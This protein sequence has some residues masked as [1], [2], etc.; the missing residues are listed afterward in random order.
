MATDSH[1]KT[2]FAYKQFCTAWRRFAHP[3][4]VLSSVI[5]DLFVVIIWLLCFVTFSCELYIAFCDSGLFALYSRLDVSVCRSVLNTA[6]QLDTATVRCWAVS[7]K[8]LFWVQ[9]SRRAIESVSICRRW[10]A[11]C[12][13][14][15]T[16]LCVRADCVCAADWPEINVV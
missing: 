13:V 6:R 4:S 9:A 1:F 11:R 10:R 3:R 7:E 2:V 8:I 16:V 12:V 14:D 5:F 15:S